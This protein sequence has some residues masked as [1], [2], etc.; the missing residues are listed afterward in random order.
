MV[1][2]AEELS[3]DWVAWGKAVGEWRHG[4]VKWHGVQFPLLSIPGPGEGGRIV[5]E[6]WSPCCE[7]WLEWDQ[8]K[9]PGTRTFTCSGCGL[10]HPHLREHRVML[11]RKTAPLPPDSPLLA[12]VTAMFELHGFHHLAA[13]LASLQ[14]RELTQLLAEELPKD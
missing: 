10:A 14:V 9:P 6:C 7:T 5:L 12:T 13:H 3:V 8:L 11:L 1:T 4:V 2:V